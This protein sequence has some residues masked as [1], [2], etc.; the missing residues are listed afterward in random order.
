MASAVSGK[1]ITECVEILAAAFG[2]TFES[3]LQAGEDLQVFLRRFHRWIDERFCFQT[4]LARLSQ[5]AEGE[6]SD[7]AKGLLT[8]DAAPRKTH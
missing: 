6:T 1:V 2:G 8:I 7:D 3:S 5:E 4:Q